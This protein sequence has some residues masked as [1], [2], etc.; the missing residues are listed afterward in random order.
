MQSRRKLPPKSWE[1]SKTGQV[2]WVS[3]D[4]ET[5]HQECRQGWNINGKE[6][7]TLLVDAASAADAEA[8]RAFI[9]EGANVKKPINSI[10]LLNVARGKG[11]FEL[12]V[13][14]GVDPNGRPVGNLYPPLL[15]AA[16]LGETDSVAILL[17]AGASVDIESADGTTA[18]MIAARS[19]V[20]A[21]VKLLLSAGADAAKKNKHGETA[22]DFARYGE[23]SDTR[24]EKHPGP[25]G[26]PPPDFRVS[27]EEIRK[28]LATAQKS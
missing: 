26:G 19:G 3:I 2:K 22:T 25:Y 12:L 10:F 6:A 4:A 15:R 11:V 9:E 27:F 21:S 23:E 8:V 7:Q 1:N 20:P 14:A 18:L 17:K 24:E 16:E 5:V 28:L 13:A